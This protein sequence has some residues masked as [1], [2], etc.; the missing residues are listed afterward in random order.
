[1]T[2]TTRDYHQEATMSTTTLTA[3]V[4]D[5][6][7]RDDRWLGFGYLGERRNRLSD[8][9]PDRPA[10]PDLVAA[11]DQRIVDHANAEGWTRDD[12]FHWANSRDGRWFGD[13]VFGGGTFD[14]AIRHRLLHRVVS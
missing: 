14:E 5:E 6:F 13:V 11:I 4:F 3:A 10:E 1:M 9:D 7:S 12:L 2:R 8:I